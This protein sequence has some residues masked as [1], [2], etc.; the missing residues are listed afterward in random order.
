MIN[1]I[2]NAIAP[3]QDN[4]RW[5]HFLV[6]SDGVDYTLTTSD[7]TGATIDA[8]N[9]TIKMPKDYKIR[10]VVYDIN[11]DTTSDVWFQKRLRLYA[12]DEQ[13]GIEIPSVTHFDYCDVWVF[14]YK[15]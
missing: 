4:G 9:K 7:V 14:A 1:T 5:Y 11:N 13:I 6:E 2:K 8:T 10:D 3:F 12:T 15:A